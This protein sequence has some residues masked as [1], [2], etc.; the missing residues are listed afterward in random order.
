VARQAGKAALAA[1]VARDLVIGSES[2]CH[3][4]AYVEPMH[5]PLLQQ[6]RVVTFHQLEAALERR[7]DPTVDVC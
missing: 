1:A 7:L 4:R 3:L 6:P 2:R 5:D